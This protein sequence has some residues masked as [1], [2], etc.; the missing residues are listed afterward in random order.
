MNSSLTP[1]YNRDEIEKLILEGLDDID[2]GNVIDGEEAFRE[3]RA[4]S[5][6]IRRKRA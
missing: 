5:A 1:E 6:Q 3:L 2:R 4:Y